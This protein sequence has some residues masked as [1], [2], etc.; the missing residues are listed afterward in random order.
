LRGRRGLGARRF[1][2]DG[3]PAGRS[4]L[5]EPSDVAVDGSGSLY[6]TDASNCRVHRVDVGGQEHIDLLIC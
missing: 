6:I 4:P 2:G 1:S 5:A 3:G